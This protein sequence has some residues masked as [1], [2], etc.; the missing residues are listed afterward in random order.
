MVVWCKPIYHCFSLET[1]SAL[2][3]ELPD[4]FQ[5][6]KWNQYI[7]DVGETHFIIFLKFILF[8]LGGGLRNMFSNS[9]WN[10]FKELLSIFALYDCV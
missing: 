5:F 7:L 8:I 6:A 4:N 1:I 2:L 9:K 3:L 10:C